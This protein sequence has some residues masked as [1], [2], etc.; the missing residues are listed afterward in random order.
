MTEGKIRQQF[1]MH[2]WSHGRNT[3]KH[4]GRN[5][6]IIKKRKAWPLTRKPFKDA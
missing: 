6:R 2:F 4:T 3:G 1:R 5:I